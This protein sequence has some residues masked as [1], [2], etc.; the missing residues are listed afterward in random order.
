V[1][2]FNGNKTLTSLTKNK[3]MRILLALLAGIFA[4]ST[5]SAA[6]FDWKTRLTEGLVD[7]DGKTVDT[8]TLAG[9]YVAVYHSAH[10]CPPC[11]LFTPKLVEF[12]NA[13]KD[14]LAVVFVSYD[15]TA[16]DMTNYMTETKM[17]WA[18]VPYKAPSGKKNAEE[19]GVKGIPSLIV[20]GPDG[21][22]LTKNG[23]D[24]AALEQLLK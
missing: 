14:K 18:A 16:A 2:R 7:A 5:A 11:K 22:L 24:L 15:K 17:P 23:R 4:S 8:A 10:W 20:Y 12:A 6:N 19:N 3:P 13:H 21:T 1:E 9:K